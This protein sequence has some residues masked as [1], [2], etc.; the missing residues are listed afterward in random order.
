MA[1]MYCAGQKFIPQNGKDGWYR[2]FRGYP[3]MSESA[4]N[5]LEEYLEDEQYNKIMLF[6]MGRC[7]FSEDYSGFLLRELMR[8]NI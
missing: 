8:G 4:L 2:T 7:E 3:K 1:N 6:F 5:M